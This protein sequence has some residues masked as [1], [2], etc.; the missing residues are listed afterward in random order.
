MQDE[1]GF[2]NDM[3]K[4]FEGLD[5]DLISDHT[6]DIIAKMLEQVGCLHHSESPQHSC[7][8]C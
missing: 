3:G 6:S 8:A 7:R 4:L 1:E 2:I 5:P